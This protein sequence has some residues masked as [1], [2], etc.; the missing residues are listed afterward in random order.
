MHAVFLTDYEFASREYAMLSRLRVGLADEG[1]RITNLVPDAVVNLWENA[2]LDRVL[3]YRSGGWWPGK[4]MLASRV[5]E[6][7]RTLEREYGPV[8]IVHAFGGGVWRLAAGLGVRLGAS[9]LVEAWRGG[10]GERIRVQWGPGRG[11]WHAGGHGRESL[12]GRVLVA[13][14]DHGIER[15][16]L[17]EQLGVPV[18]VCPWGVH[19]PSSPIVPASAKAD[20]PPGIL[21]VGGDNEPDALRTAVEAAVGVERG[22]K[23][24]TVFVD[25]RGAKRAG[26]WAFVRK[27]GAGGRLSVIDALEHQRALALSADVLIYPSPRADRRTILL[28][29]IAASVPVVATAESPVPQLIDGQTCL[30]VREPGAAAWRQAIDALFSNRDIVEGLA[31]SGRSYVRE[32]HKVSTHVASVVEAYDWLGG[33][34]AIPISTAS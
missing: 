3:A 11:G 12:D 19:V 20:R 26:L 7:L 34:Q 4:G 28:D 31:K 33:R 10:L 13:A 18:R 2:T 24:A 17:K 14:P 16:L 5:E 27:L 32:H 21:V 1:I 23:P 15:E 6:E 29:A 8:D 25:T 30:L 22:G 9:V